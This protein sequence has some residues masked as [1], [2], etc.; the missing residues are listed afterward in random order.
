MI[1]ARVS[2]R[3]NTNM[4]NL[5]RKSIEKF[6]LNLFM[7]VSIRIIGLAFLQTLVGQQ[8]I[9]FVS[10]NFMKLIVILSIIVFLAILI[11][12]RNKYL[13]YKK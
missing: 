5:E 10:E 7:F 3:R 9:R 1:G 12:I 8:I 13:K 2:I 11:V 4:R 6:L